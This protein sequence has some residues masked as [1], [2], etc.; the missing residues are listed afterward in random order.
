MGVE[1]CRSQS[2]RVGF[3]VPVKCLAR[4]PCRVRIGGG[5]ILGDLI[6]GSG[7]VPIGVGVN[8]EKVDAGEGVG[9]CVGSSKSVF[10]SS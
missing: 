9:V 3:W 5:T 7:V 10:F 6:S 8:M 2:E 1:G 4:F